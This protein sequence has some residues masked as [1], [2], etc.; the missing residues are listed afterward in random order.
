MSKKEKIQMAIEIFKITL[1][2]AR[3]K[4]MA[5]QNEANQNE[6]D[7]FSE[8]SFYCSVNIKSRKIK[9]GVAA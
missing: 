4:L 3:G 6:I 1:P 2:E 5:Y 8:D 7:I 9:G